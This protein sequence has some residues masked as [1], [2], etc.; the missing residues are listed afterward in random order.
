MRLSL[1]GLL[2]A[3]GKI[4]TYMIQNIYNDQLFL[5]IRF[6][7]RSVNVKVSPTKL[8][9]AYTEGLLSSSIELIDSFT[10]SVDEDRKIRR[11]S[12]G[13]MAPMVEGERDK[14][15]QLHLVVALA[16]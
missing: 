8:T 1:T 9:K 12:S 14:G 4:I 11:A 16:S 3:L 6:C 15:A 13:I 5:K 10:F 2:H 7:V